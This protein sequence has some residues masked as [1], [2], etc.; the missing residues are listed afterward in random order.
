MKERGNY[1]LLALSINRPWPLAML[2]VATTN[3][4]LST[5]YANTIYDCKV[6]GF[7]EG[8]LPTS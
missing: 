7:G 6:N 3:T 5:I 1:S 8:E 4:A 2:L